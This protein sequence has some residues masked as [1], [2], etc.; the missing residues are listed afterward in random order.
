MTRGCIGKIG[1][2][3]VGEASQA[4]ARIKARRTEKRDE[5]KPYRCKL[6][7]RVHL[8]R[9]PKRTRH[10]RRRGLWAAEIAKWKE[11]TR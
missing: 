9:D 2:A 4:L 11:L 6:C 8:G 1:Y 3:T 7:D 10:R 5:L